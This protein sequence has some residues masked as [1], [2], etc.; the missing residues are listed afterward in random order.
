MSC[1][2]ISRRLKKLGLPKFE[3]DAYLL[4]KDVMHADKRILHQE[5]TALDEISSILD[6]SKTTPKKKK[7]KSKPRK[8]SKKKR[9]EKYNADPDFAY[10][11][12]Y[13]PDYEI[14]QSLAN[15]FQKWNNR[16][17]TVPAHRRDEIQKKIDLIAWVRKEYD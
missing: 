4:A 16:L 13:A 7:R 1:A 17:N 12:A 3:R 5:T 14:K 10:I 8:V 15:E 11:D 6:I 2:S 9:L